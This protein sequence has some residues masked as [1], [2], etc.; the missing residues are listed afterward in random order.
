MKTGYWL[1]AAQVPVHMVHDATFHDW[2]KSEHDGADWVR[3]P[4]TESSTVVH[5]VYNKREFAQLWTRW[6]RDGVQYGT[7]GEAASQRRQLGD[8]GG[9]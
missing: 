1:G 5:H 6:A 4:V 2:M 3:K 7:A 8:G 9:S